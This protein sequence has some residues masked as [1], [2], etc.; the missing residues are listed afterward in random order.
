MAQTGPLTD[1]TQRL[2]QDLK[3]KNEE[4]R[5][6]GAYELYD[7]VLAVSRG[8]YIIWIFIYRSDSTNS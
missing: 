4:T 5:V 8:I 7:N 6:R 1:F 2:F 3:S